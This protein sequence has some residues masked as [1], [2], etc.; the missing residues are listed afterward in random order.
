MY[1]FPSVIV[2]FIV[3]ISNP[4]LFQEK[5]ISLPPRIDCQPKA[6][7]SVIKEYRRAI[8]RDSAVIVIVKV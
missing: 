2:A 5:A 1:F 3:A 4:D 6:N 8:K 7:I